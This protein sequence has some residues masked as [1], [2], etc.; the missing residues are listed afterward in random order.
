MS[1]AYVEHDRVIEDG[2]EEALRVDGLLFRLD[3]FRL[4]CRRPDRHLRLDAVFGAG[5]RL[6]LVAVAVASGQLEA[7]RVEELGRVDE[8]VCA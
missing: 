4:L 5:D 2:T 6:G 3:H 7:E 8:A 1:L